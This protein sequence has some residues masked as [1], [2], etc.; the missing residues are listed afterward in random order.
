M[1][2]ILKIRAYILIPGLFIFCTN[3]FSCNNYSSV[4]N[5]YLIRVD[6]IHAPDS[7]IQNEG[8]DV[9]FF[10]IIGLNT[11]QHFKSFNIDYN[12]KDVHIEAWGTDNSKG[13]ICG[14]GI[15]YLN[16]QKVTIKLYPSGTYRIKITDPND[17]TLVKQ[18]VVK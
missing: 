7:V 1:L 9:V 11:C 15:V 18:I 3:F 14:E 10:G 8:F 4:A 2:I 16:G 12:N 5:D 17:I 6:S 13:E